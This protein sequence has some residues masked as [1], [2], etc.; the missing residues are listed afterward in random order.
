MMTFEEFKTDVLDEVKKCPEDWRFG[1]SVFNVIDYRYGVA[2]NVQFED[3]IDCFYNNDN[4][5]PFILLSY[6]K[7]CAL[8]SQ[9]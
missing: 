6:A 3:G 7:Y 2:R 8:A 4:V 5:D 1:Q 9:E